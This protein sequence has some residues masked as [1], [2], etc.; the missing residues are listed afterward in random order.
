[1]TMICFIC[2]I[3]KV[4]TPKHFDNCLFRATCRITFCMALTLLPFLHKIHILFFNL[5]FI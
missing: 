4:G 5:V 3:V 1:M 2:C